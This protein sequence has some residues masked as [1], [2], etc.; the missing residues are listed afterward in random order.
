M[1][2][3]YVKGTT[4]PKDLIP[5]LK[6]RGLI[7]S[8]E[9]KAVSYLTNI[10]YFRFSAY[11][12]PL[13]KNPKTAHQFKIGATFEMALDMYRFD[14]KL[15]ILLFDEIEKIEVAIRTAMNNLVSDA[16]NDVFWMT[17]N[18]HFVNP[19][20]FT[21][22]LSL[23][24]SELDR[25][26][27]EFIAHFKNKYIETFPPAW[28]ISEIIPLGVLCSIFNNIQ[29]MRIKK[30]VAGQ[31][32]LSV[33]VFSSWILIL[34]I[35][36]NVC[37]HHNRAWNKDHLVIPANIQS[38]VFH[39]I[40]NTKTDAKRIYY[41]ICIIKYLLFTVSPNSQFT[42]KLKSLLEEYP[43]VDIRAM[44]FPADWENEPLWKA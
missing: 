8:D 20:S 44:G 26:K 15:R 13:L 40:D 39:W 12:H 10:S 18:R 43:T 1:K 4:Q 22:S 29:S 7:I 11:L 32:G 41:R 19:T 5:L 25:S 23:I 38:P 2:V 37:C 9:Q 30:M 3:S 6:S 31:F 33:P 28:M 34:S 16:L 14:R 35:L 27:E 17:E 36:R 21:K 24:Q 42:E